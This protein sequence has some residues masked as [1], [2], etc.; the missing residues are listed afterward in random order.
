MNSIHNIIIILL[1]VIIMCDLIYKQY[2]RM[3]IPATDNIMFN[4]VMRVP[5]VSSLDD[6]T[7]VWYVLVARSFRSVFHFGE[8]QRTSFLWLN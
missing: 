8:K 2:A 4:S 3:R 1:N 5:I 7:L 6:V